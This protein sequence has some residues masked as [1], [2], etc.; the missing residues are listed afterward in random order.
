LLGPRSC[1][2]KDKAV[3][4]FASSTFD[5]KTLVYDHLPMDAECRAFAIR[6]AIEEVGERE[7]EM[8]DLRDRVD[9]LE[10]VSEE[11]ASL[12]RAHGDLE[13]ERDELK[14]ERDELKAM[15]DAREARTVELERSVADLEERIAGF[16]TR[17]MDPDESA[18]HEATRDALRDLVQA[19]EGVKIGKTARVGNLIVVGAQQDFASLLAGAL[20]A[21]KAAL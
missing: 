4:N 3:Q 17:V 15:F 9:E 8:A 11:L 21:A 20:E 5:L 7:Q 14:K 2:E 1:A 6:Q 18:K 13:E 16:D 12:N 10:T 19:I